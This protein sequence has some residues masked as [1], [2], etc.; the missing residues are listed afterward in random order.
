MNTKPFHE[1]I[2]DAIS[3][4]TG[5]GEEA[6]ERLKVLGELLISTKIPKDHELISEKFKEA[7]S[8]FGDGKMQDLLFQ[9][10]KKLKEEM[11]AV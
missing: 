11:A 9:V 4:C 1:S 2:C 7:I 10:F 8:Y 5:P 6:R 3:N